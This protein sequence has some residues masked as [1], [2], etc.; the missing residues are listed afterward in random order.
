MPYLRV[1]EAP[2]FL[3]QS[4]GVYMNWNIPV[5]DKT[6]LTLGNRWQYNNLTHD[7][8]PQPQVRLS[9]ELASNQRIWAGWGK[10]I[11][12]PSR[13]E[14]S[15]YLRE[16]QYMQNVMFSDNNYYDYYYSTLLKGNEDL[17]VESV[18]TYELG[19]RFGMNIVCNSASVVL[20]QTRKHSRL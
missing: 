7:I 4:Y 5:M 18:S 12:T 8:D 1:A 10:A 13:L 2:D 3:N 11:V 6:K 20:H 15:T 19:Y 9:Y 16:N 17:D 14:L